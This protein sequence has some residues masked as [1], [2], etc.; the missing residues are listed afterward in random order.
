MPHLWEKELGAVK[1]INLVATIWGEKACKWG[2]KQEVLLSE[3]SCYSHFLVLC[4]CFQMSPFR[5]KGGG[6]IW[7]Q[8]CGFTL[9]FSSLLH[10][11]IWD[12]TKPGWDLQTWQT[13][14]N[15][16]WAWTCSQSTVWSFSAL[17]FS[18]WLIAG[19]TRCLEISRGSLLSVRMGGREGRTA[20]LGRDTQFSDLFYDTPQM[21]STS[22]E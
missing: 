20:F 8:K 22:W 17:S 15:E 16:S 4:K 19:I 5:V 7:V 6:C 13:P 21:K 18:T 1:R 2:W 12:S 10:R 9:G 3:S 14:S 11:G